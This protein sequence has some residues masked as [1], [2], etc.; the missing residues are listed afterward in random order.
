MSYI[1]VVP[2]PYPSV[3][4]LTDTPWSSF[5]SNSTFYT[6]DNDRCFLCVFPLFPTGVSLILVDIFTVQ[7]HPESQNNKKATKK[8]VS[9]KQRWMWPVGVLRHNGDL[10]LA[11]W[12]VWVKN[13]GFQ[14]FSILELQVRDFGPVVPRST[15]FLPCYCVVVS[16][17]V[18]TIQVQKIYWII[19]HFADTITWQFM[20]HFS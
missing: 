2:T 20:H 17:T 19:C 18:L 9:E 1:V 11:L 3:R 4:C 13:F 10:T 15:I 8:T 14:N 5:Y 7:L 12:V 6:I 16:E